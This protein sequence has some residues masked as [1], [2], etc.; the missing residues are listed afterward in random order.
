M[1]KERRAEIRNAKP[2]YCGA[3]RSSELVVVW[4]TA[5]EQHY[6]GAASKRLILAMSLL[7]LPPPEPFPIYSSLYDAAAHF[8]AWERCFQIYV[9][10]AGISDDTRQRDTFQYVAGKY[11]QQLVPTLA[12]TG[13]D[14]DGLITAAADYFQS[15]QSPSMARFHFRQVTQQPGETLDTFYTRLLASATTCSFADDAQKNV[16]L[17]D[18]IVA[19][20]T[21]DLLRR[22]LLETA[23]LD[24]AKALKAARAFEASV[25]QTTAFRRTQDSINALRHQPPFY[26][27]TQPPPA[28]VSTPSRQPMQSSPHPAANSYHQPPAP[29]ATRA[30]GQRE[31]STSLCYRCGEPD[32]PESRRYAV[33]HCKRLPMGVSSASEILQRTL[34]AMAR[35]PRRCEELP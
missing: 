22:K 21:S 3:F 6:I 31:S 8:P 18:Q 4:N 25:E 17:C 23:S 16:A 35:W 2:H 34:D 19:G 28:T 11:I 1:T 7:S 15:K 12:N 10:A 13:N 33:L 14:L 26:K 30:P 9:A 29:V 24:L 27:R 5:R 32:H 20:C